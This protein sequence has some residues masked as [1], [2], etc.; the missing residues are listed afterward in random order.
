[1]FILD[2]WVWGSISDLTEWGGWACTPHALSNLCL[3]HPA[4]TWR[5]MPC[6]GAGFRAAD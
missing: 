1:V 5:G 3:Q 4:G 2:V 6:A